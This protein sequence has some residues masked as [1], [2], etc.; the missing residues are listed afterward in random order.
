[1]VEQSKIE[2]AGA[3]APQS[4]DGKRVYERSTIEFPYNDLDDAVEIAK[5]IHSNA[6]MSCTLDQLAAYLHVAM[7]GGAFNGRVAN[8]GTFRIAKRSGGMVTLSS[9]GLRIVDP[10]TEAEARAEAFLSV[11]LYSAIHDKYRGYSLPP[12]AALEREMQALGVAGKQTDK[13]RQAFMRSAKQAGFFAHGEDRLVRPSFGAGPTTKPIEPPPEE[14]PKEK[15]RGGGEPPDGLHPFILG[16]LK[17]LPKA[18]FDD[19]GAPLTDWSGP[20]RQKWLQ[21]A[22]NIFDLIYKG[23]GG[24]EI[25]SALAQRSPRP[26]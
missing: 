19:D 21:T 1:M 4:Q 3:G 20:A 11:P 12:A 24:I 14:K 26:E 23:E 25:R 9:I 7:T 10:N 6:G 13:A 2:N 16:L 5:T 22:A 18:T 8:A 17:S 15:S